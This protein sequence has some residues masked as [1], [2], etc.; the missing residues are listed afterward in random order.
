MI[1]VDNKNKLRISSATTA[2]DR[3][4]TITHI[5]PSNDTPNYWDHDF[6]NPGY[7][8]TPA[9]YLMMSPPDP[10]QMTHDKNGRKAYSLPTQSGIK[11]INLGPHSKTSIASH[12]SDSFPLI[13]ESKKTCITILADRGSDF[14]VNH[15]MNELFRDLH[16]DVLL[17]TTH[18]P[19]F[20]ARNPIEHVWSVLTRAS[21]SI[22]LLDHL[23]GKSN[24]AKEPD[25]N[26]RREKEREAF[27]SAL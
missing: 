21:V 9:G 14:N 27:D 3:R 26:I 19:G 24:P 18:C 6:P 12:A 11:V 2:V 13:Q 4:C 1:S 16:L 15:L 7:L 5:F 10:P 25:G 8:I 22:Y 17:A 20:S 23:P